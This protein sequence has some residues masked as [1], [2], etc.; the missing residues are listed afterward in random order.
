M[1][2]EHSKNPD[3]VKT[4]E[5]DISFRQINKIKDLNIQIT[6]EM[7]REFYEINNNYLNTILRFVTRTQTIIINERIL[8]RNSKSSQKFQRI[9]PAEK[10]SPSKKSRGG[11][12]K[13][14]KSNINFGDIPN[15]NDISSYNFSNIS[16]DISQYQKSFVSDNDA[17]S[18]S[19]INFLKAMK[20]ITKSVLKEIKQK[21]EEI[22][23]KLDDV[24]QQDLQVESKMNGPG[25][26]NIPRS[27]LSL[28]LNREEELNSISKA[29]Q[30][31]ES[32]IPNDMSEHNLSFNSNIIEDIKCTN[33]IK[34]NRNNKNNY[35]KSQKTNKTNLKNKNEKCNVIPITDNNI[36]NY[37]IKNPNTNL[38]NKKVTQEQPKPFDHILQNKE[39]DPKH[40]SVKK[41]TTN[42]SANN[43][44]SNT[45]QVEQTS[46]NQKKKSSACRCLIF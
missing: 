37:N 7:L 15:Q 10:T 13:K 32:N 3:L 8:V 35:V 18:Q 14:L 1:Y 25:E 31:D 23:V 36:S 26:N 11:R 40:Q 5:L 27:P 6:Q 44:L 43:G 46:R 9:I 45:L 19:K 24:V 38:E 17:A 30:L 20:G 28:G 34:L 4:P 12:R 2:M 16:N 41:D 42:S 29:M 39:N 33:T 21:G 22:P